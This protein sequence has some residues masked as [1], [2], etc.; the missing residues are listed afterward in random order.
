MTYFCLLS[1]NTVYGERTSR[2]LLTL[3]RDQLITL[4]VGPC[5]P[6][7]DGHEISRLYDS[8]EWYTLEYTTPD[9]GITY[10]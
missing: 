4:F 1:L 8:L 6:Q 5:W 2:N 10:S 7:H 3:K 9:Y